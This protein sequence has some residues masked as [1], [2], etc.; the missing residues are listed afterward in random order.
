M[1][2]NH[3]RGYKSFVTEISRF[4]FALRT[5]P[6][7]QILYRTL[8]N[9]DR[10]FQNGGRPPPKSGICDQK[11]KKYFLKPEECDH[12]IWGSP[13]NNCCAILSISQRNGLFGGGPMRPHGTQLLLWAA[14]PHGLGVLSVK[15]L[16]KL[17]SVTT[18][19]H[20]QR[21][22]WVTLWVTL[23]ATNLLFILPDSHAPLPG[24]NLHCWLWIG[25]WT[26][27]RYI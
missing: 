16:Q 27:H 13:F 24:Y 3:W 6:K 21:T 11:L 7:D 8:R 5:S 15:T 10:V 9:V 22:S 4:F 23:S 25:H 2:C 18:W 17:R 20:W 1:F 12:T 26:L 14:G 19:S